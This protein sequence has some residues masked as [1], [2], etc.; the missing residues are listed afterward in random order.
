MFGN[1]I[2]V[3][4]VEKIEDDCHTEYILH[5][6]KWLKDKGFTDKELRLMRDL[7]EWKIYNGEVYISAREYMNIHDKLDYLIDKK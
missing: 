5:L 4:N 3:E 6:G 1:E 7:I 2:D